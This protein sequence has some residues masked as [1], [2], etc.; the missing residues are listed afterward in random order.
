MFRC[1]R[2]GII[3]T[4]L[5]CVGCASL[6]GVK[7]K[8]VEDRLN[9]P[10]FREENLPIRTLRV[11]VIVSGFESD[12]HVRGAFSR[13][14]EIFETQTG[15]RFAVTIYR[16][17]EWKTHSFFQIHPVLREFRKTHLEYD[18]IVGASLRFPRKDQWCFLGTCYDGMIDDGRNI[19]ILQ[20]VPTTIVHE[21]GHA[22]LGI[23][24]STSGIM[25]PSVESAYFTHGDRKK[26]LRR[27]WKSFHYEAPKEFWDSG[28]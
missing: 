22:F 1:L 19:A 10:Q 4:T 18:I 13:A 3:F 21:V 17:P 14:S 7:E 12:E 23:W 8:T 28:Y 16:E 15:I 2:W 11:A 6:S 9:D 26:I 25:T 5:F 27:K 20:L 24:H